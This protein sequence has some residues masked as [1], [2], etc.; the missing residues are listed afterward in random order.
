MIKHFI[1]VDVV[2]EKPCT[3][4]PTL[5]CE[6]CKEKCEVRIGNRT[7]DLREDAT[8]K[9]QEGNLEDR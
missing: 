8:E 2:G 4:D 6:W 5:Q 3:A 7:R 1:Y 9:G